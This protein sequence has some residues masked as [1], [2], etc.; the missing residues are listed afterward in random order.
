MSDTHVFVIPARGGSKRLLR[1][2]LRILWGKPLIRHSVD[3][4]CNAAVGG[5]RV[6]SIS[7]ED[8]EVLEYARSVSGVLAI[9]RPPELAQDDVPTQPVLKHAVLEVEASIGTR[10]DIVWWM[11]ACVPQVTSADLL[12]GYRFLKEKNLR[13]VT[14]V[15]SEG[16][17]Y[18]AVRLMQRQVLFADALSTHFGVIR[19]DYVDVHLQSDLVYLEGLRH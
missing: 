19:R 17:A 8:P 4:A 7:S 16:L 10:A 13:E 1:K 2:N 15:N 3:A 14:T 12:E 6:I 11:N 9:M 18:A 5:R